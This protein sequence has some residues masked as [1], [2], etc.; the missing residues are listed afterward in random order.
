MLAMPELLTASLPM[1]VPESLKVTEPLVTFTFTPAVRVTL[2]PKVEEFGDTTRTV[3]VGTAASAGVVCTQE[4]PA[5]PQNTIAIRPIR[6][7]I[8]LSP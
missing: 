8:P 1:V 4:A 3:A 7:A 6:I 2:W 5:S